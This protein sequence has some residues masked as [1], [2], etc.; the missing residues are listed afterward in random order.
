MVKKDVLLRRAN[1]KKYFYP[2]STIPYALPAETQFDQYITTIP[3]KVVLAAMGPEKIKFDSKAN[4]LSQLQLL[5]EAFNKN[6]II[7]N[8][9]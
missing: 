5:K 4:F 7:I 8:N 2:T 6:T 9:G 3:V 1:I